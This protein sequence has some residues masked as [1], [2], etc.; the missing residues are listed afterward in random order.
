VTLEAFSFAW[1][2]AGTAGMANA[3]LSS[4][5]I[6]VGSVVLVIAVSSIG[7][8]VLARRIGRLSNTMYFLFLLGYIVP[9]Q[10]AILPI[11]S[12][13][14]DLGLLGNLLGMIVLEAGFMMP[15]G[16][17]LYTGFIRVLP[18]GYEDAAR[19][20]GAGDFRAFRYVV[21][22]LLRPVTGTVAVLGSMFVWND[23]FTSLLFLS[24]SDFETVPVAVYSF[25]GEFAAQWPTIFAA[26]LISIVPI[27]L[28]YI[29]AQRQLMQG[30]SGGVK[31]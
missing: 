1:L 9:V 6:T 5:I 13:F 17:I 29:F 20:D 24:G 4:V 2:E 22:P 3:L 31:G 30:F 7:A 15:L 10:L 27:L 21:F 18:R 28:F 19:I 16:I 26:V 14:S 23:F 12:A 11:Y 25:V 8:F